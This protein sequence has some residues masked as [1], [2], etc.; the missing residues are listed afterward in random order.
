[1]A[2]TITPQNEQQSVTQSNAGTEASLPLIFD[3]FSSEMTFL[4]L[5]QL[6][7]LQDPFRYRILLA[8]QQGRE[9]KIHRRLTHRTRG[10][11]PWAPVLHNAEGWSLNIRR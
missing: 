11:M 5:G 2:I 8:S 7:T 10:A 3:S 6:F 9:D 1:M 4:Q